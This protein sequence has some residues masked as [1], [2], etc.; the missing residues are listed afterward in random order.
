VRGDPARLQQVLW[1][2]LSNA[3]KFT[4]RGGSVSIRMRQ[5]AEEAPAQGGPQQPSVEIEVSDTGQGI[6]RE[7]LPHVFERFRQADASAARQHNGLGLGLAIVKHLIEQ[8]G[9]SVVAQSD[10]EGLGTTV[11]VSIPA[12]AGRDAEGPGG[13]GAP[14][15]QAEPELRSLRGVRVLVVD[16]E[17]D[18]RELVRRVLEDC[19]A[20]VATAAS[21][22]EGLEM[23]STF[24]PDVLVSDIGMPGNDGY[25]FIR[26]VRS[27]DCS[28]RREIPAAALTAFARAEDHQ[29]VLT[30]GYQVHVPKP[31]EPSA[32]VATIAR[33]AERAG[34]VRLTASGNGADGHPHL[35]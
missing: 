13:P 29:R 21:A 2:L 16:D 24:G 35:T 8:H 1:N 20:N 28:S 12:E 26:Q 6:R 17:A 31:V 32:L 9:G 23:L 4:P 34:T 14:R 33:L 10:G 30:A 3:I 25:E 27:L 22:S 19:E 15:P 7:F 11:T 5:V 18:A